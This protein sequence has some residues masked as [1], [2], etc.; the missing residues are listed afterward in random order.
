MKTPLLTIL[1]LVLSANLAWGQPAV[2]GPAPAFKI[3]TGADK[4]K[5]TIT[6]R[7]T[8][9]HAVPVQK[10]IAVNINGQ[11]VNKVVTEYETRTVEVTI[12]LPV[13]DTRIITAGGKQIPIDELWKRVKAD[14]VIVLSGN[15]DAPSQAYLRALNPET[16]VFIRSAPK[17]APE[18][19]KS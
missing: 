9:T 17:Q 3:V 7:D 2:P 13:A 1:G 11:V 16:I 12:M 18:P 19:K 5:G 15:H 4:D 10:I 6:Y 14:S 8:V